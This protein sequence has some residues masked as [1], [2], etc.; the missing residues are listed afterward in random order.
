LNIGECFAA[1][2]PAKGMSK[3]WK[4]LVPVFG[5]KFHILDS[6]GQNRK[7]ESIRKVA[8]LLI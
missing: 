8:M 1:L 2:R 7:L 4:Q 5:Y 3:K 6:Y